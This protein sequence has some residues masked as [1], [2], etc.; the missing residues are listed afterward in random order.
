MSKINTNLESWFRKKIAEVNILG[1]RRPK[2]ITVVVPSYERQDFLLR[3][4]IYWCDSDVQLLVLDGSDK[5]LPKNIL[6]IV[7]ELENVTYLHLPISVENRLNKAINF[8]KTPYVVSLSDDEF[9]LKSTLEKLANRLDED[10]NLSGCIG[11]SLRFNFHRDKDVIDYSKG[12]PHLGF[13]AEHKEVLERIKYGMNPYNAA[14][15]YGLLRKDVWLEGW[16]EIEKYSC[17]YVSEIYQAIVTYVCGKYIAID[18]LYWLR[19]DENAPV[20]INN[21]NRQFEFDQWWADRS[22]LLEK[23][24]F[25]NRLQKIILNR[26]ELNSDEAKSILLESINSY[27]KF[28]TSKLN[29]MRKFLTKILRIVLP[30]TV[31]HYLKNRILHDEFSKNYNSKYQWQKFLKSENYLNKEKE[32][33]EIELLVKEFT[34]CRSK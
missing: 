26:T 22:F 12:Y 13:R 29:K 18:D 10:K 32:M 2:N 21:E 7:N 20:E 34:L 3:Q 31:Y 16:G 15:S 6:I 27:L 19:S 33:E 8:I 14:T 5:P 1:E 24:K 23:N 28:S 30:H 4:F 11:Q 9:L 17:V 25:L